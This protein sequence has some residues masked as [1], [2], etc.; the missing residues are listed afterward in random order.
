MFEPTT[1]TFRSH[2]DLRGT[3]ALT[4]PGVPHRVHGFLKLVE[5]RPALPALP[6]MTTVVLLA[7]TLRV[8]G[9]RGG[10]GHGAGR[11]RL[12]AREDLRAPNER[13]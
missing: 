1:R 3:A 6:L 7:L 4:R 11:T 5:A 13:G 12:S 10:A 8:R 9:H 2:G